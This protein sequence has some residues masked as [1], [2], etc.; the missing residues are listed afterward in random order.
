MLLYLTF[1]C[2]V[3]TDKQSRDNSI[4]SQNS[5]TED[6]KRRLSSDTSCISDISDA[7]VEVDEVN[8]RK[9]TAKKCVQRLFSPDTRNDILLDRIPSPEDTVTQSSCDSQLTPLHCVSPIE[10]TDFNKDLPLFSES[11]LHLKTSIKEKLHQ[12][13]TEGEKEKLTNTE[14]TNNLTKLQVKENT[15]AQ[16]VE[17]HFKPIVRTQKPKIWSISEILG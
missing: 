15:N 11:F 6:D 17:N 13:P 7:D 14:N 2:Y 3:F 16:T 4:V 9:K 1:C 10:S 12:G 5:F 8:N